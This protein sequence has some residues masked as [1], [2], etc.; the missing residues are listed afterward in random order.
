[1]WVG[2]ICVHSGIY[3]KGV[4]VEWFLLKRQIVNLQDKLKEFKFEI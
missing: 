3:I 1:M 2:E 4:D